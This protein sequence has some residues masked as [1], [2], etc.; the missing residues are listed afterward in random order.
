MILSENSFISRTI[1]FVKEALKGAESGHDWWH[2]SRVLSNAEA[3]LP[4]MPSANSLVVRMAALLHDVDDWKFKESDKKGLKTKTEVFLE[5]LE[6]EPEIMQKII[7]V[8]ETVSYK[9]S[10]VSDETE[11]L[12]GKIVQDAD[13]LDALGAIGIARC[14][15]YGGYRQREMYNP[16]KKPTM[17]K[18]FE[19][20][21]GNTEGTSL[22]HFYEKLLLLKDRMKTAK[23]KEMAEA[24]HEYM[25]GFLERFLGEWEGK[26]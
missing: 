23:G 18:S 11:S 13:R 19:E 20:Y 9:G 15:S 24:R 22:N 7:S 10:G 4:T 6:L 17:H 12:E 21:K 2:I 8:I 26:A 25:L 3:I 5:S 1:I 16:E 14:F